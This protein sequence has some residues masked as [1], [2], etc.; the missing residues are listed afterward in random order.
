M[1]GSSGDRSLLELRQKAE[2]A[3]ERSVKSGEVEPLLE[4]ILA[5]APKGSDTALFAHRHLAELRLERNPW[6]AALHVR[7]LLAYEEHDDV[8][9]ALMGLCQAL[10]GNYR[11]AVTS[12]RKAL[13]EAPRTPW[14][15]HNLG[16]LLDVAMG[17]AARAESHLRT[18]HRMQPEH[19]EIAASLAHC[20]ARLDLLDEARSLAEEAVELAP[21][22]AGHRSMLRWILDGAP[23][24]RTLAT[25][26]SPHGKPPSAPA[27]EPKSRAVRRAFE[28]R[29]REVGFSLDQIDGARSLWADFHEGRRVRMKKPEVYA[30][31]VEYAIAL[32]H[33]QS[34]ITQVSV[35]RRY[36]VAPG[37]LSSR[38]GEIREA[39]DL[40]PND[41][42]YEAE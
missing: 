16:H 14:Y 26:P 23:P 4:R 32:I 10:L 13:A 30:A 17:D 33:G 19:D 1:K 27:S 41:P 31:A 39:L 15:H 22:S 5:R 40:L 28:D 11:A 35:A 8:L 18:A 38:Y 29:M 7:E 36:G 34:G 3:L 42:R 24:D 9:H 25:S 2:D 12:Y 37:S 20:L 21:D 6:R